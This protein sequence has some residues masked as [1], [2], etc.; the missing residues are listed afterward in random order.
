MEE[1]KIE[2]STAAGH[3]H[4]RK[5]SVFTEKSGVEGFLHV[6][7]KFLKVGNR[8]VF[9]VADYWDQFGEVLDTMAEDKWMSLIINIAVPA[10]KMARWITTVNAL[11]QIY[12]EDDNPRDILINY[13]KS[14]ECAKSRSKNPGT[15][16]SRIQV[17]CRIANRLEGHEARLNDE[18]IKKYVFDSFPLHWINNYKKS[19]LDYATDTVVGVI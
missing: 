5:T 6:L 10:R 8:L 7:D 11:L 3:I 14:K 2:I 13:I 1:V 18:Q 15:H 16:A 9:Q 12:G 4:S 17:L 19:R